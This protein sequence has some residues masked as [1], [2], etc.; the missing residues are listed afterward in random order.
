[1]YERR[2]SLL[3]MFSRAAS[4][5]LAQSNHRFLFVNPY[6][7]YLPSLASSHHLSLAL[8]LLMIFVQLILFNLLP[9]GRS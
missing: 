8:G 7:I 3:A 1:M 2:T 4:G 9:L 5:L 6:V